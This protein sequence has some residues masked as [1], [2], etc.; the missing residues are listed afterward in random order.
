M[1]EDADEAVYEV[2]EVLPVAP[3]VDS[4]GGI[5]AVCGLSGAH[6]G[7]NS[8]R[9]GE[10][11]QIRFVAS[12]SHPVTRFALLR[13]GNETDDVRFGLHLPNDLADLFLWQL[14]LGEPD[15]VERASH[16]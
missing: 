5:P 7:A 2:P 11:G 8:G 15:D 3:M 9:I 1:I 16:V 10:K 4:R 12:I 13:G 14:R 6:K